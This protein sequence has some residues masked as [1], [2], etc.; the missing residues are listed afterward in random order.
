[1]VTSGSI[2]LLP[3]PLTWTSTS[4]ARKKDS[5]SCMQHSAAARQKLVIAIKE[6]PISLLKMLVHSTMPILHFVVENEQLVNIQAKF[7]FSHRAM[8]ATASKHAIV[9]IMERR[10]TY[11]RHR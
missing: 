8:P 7:A 6:P 11:T 3:N 4:N 2:V 9:G 10:K 1:M 5:V